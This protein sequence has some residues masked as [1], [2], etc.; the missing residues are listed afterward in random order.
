MLI[1]ILKDYHK[2][3]Y[4]APPRHGILPE[5]FPNCNMAVRKE[6]FNDIGLYRD[7]PIIT[8]EEVDLCYRAYC[9]GWDLFYQPSAKCDHEPREKISG[10][11]KQW[12]RYGYY[13]SYFFKKHQQERCN[14]FF[15]FKFQTRLEDYRRIIKLKRFPFKSTIFITMFSL[16]QILLLVMLVSFLFKFI[17]LAIIAAALSLLPLI[18]VLPVFWKTVGLKKIPLYFF[19]TYIIYFSCI[20]GS[21]LG[22]FKNRMLYFYSGV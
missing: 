11:I 3:G 6:M 1:P 16:I 4:V 7:D 14:I 5:F 9:G 15:S 17:T 12:F 19:F 20:T 2:K 8:A 10:V 22:G 13:S 18:Q 21:I